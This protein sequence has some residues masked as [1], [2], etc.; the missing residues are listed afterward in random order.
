MCVCVYVCVCVCVYVCV[1]VCAYLFVC[2]S[3]EKEKRKDSKIKEKIRVIITSWEKEIHFLF[4]YL[5]SSWEDVDLEV[6]VSSVKST[7]ITYKT[8]QVNWLHNCH[9]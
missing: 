6:T 9:H 7:D 8:L 3:E 5:Q 2:V 1:C 4:K